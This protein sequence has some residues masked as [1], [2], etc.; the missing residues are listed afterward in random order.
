MGEP[1]GGRIVHLRPSTVVSLGIEC[2]QQGRNAL[3]QC[4]GRR[5]RFSLRKQFATADRTSRKRGNGRLTAKPKE[6]STFR[7]FMILQFV[8][9]GEAAALDFG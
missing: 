2:P 1:L 9:R 5:L 8:S 4:A 3:L 7:G 6:I